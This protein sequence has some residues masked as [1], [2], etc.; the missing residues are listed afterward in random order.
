MYKS[1]NQV[2]YSDTEV[3]FYLVVSLQFQYA[4]RQLPYILWDMTSCVGFAVINM[5][6]AISYLNEVVFSQWRSSLGS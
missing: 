4:L 2:G 1:G 5:L 6:K 3:T